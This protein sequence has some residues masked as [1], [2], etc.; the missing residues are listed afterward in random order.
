MTSIERQVYE[1]VTS[2]LEVRQSDVRPDSTWDDYGADSL[3]IVELVFALEQHFRISF[4]IPELERMKSVADMVRVIECKV[5]A[6]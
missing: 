3:A 2:A 6:G 4:E 1:I 5:G